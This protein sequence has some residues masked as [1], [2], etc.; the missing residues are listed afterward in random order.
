MLSLVYQE[1]NRDFPKHEGNE[2][3]MNFDSRNFEPMGSLRLSDTSKINIAHMVL[4][5]SSNMEVDIQ[6]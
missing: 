4:R 6:I 2:E 3:E 5:N 1:V